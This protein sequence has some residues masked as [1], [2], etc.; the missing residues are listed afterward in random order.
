M[1]FAPATDQTVKATCRMVAR[2]R[3]FIL[4][5]AAYRYHL[6]HG[7]L[8]ASFAEID[9]SLV[10]GDM[11]WEDLIQDPFD[12]QSLRVRSDDTGLLIYSVFQNLVDD[13]GD[14]AINNLKPQTGDLGFQVTIP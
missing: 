9:R 7:R 14:V 10:P 2:Q 8:P 4:G 12:G 5:L 11:R 6:K 3:C 1:L 13:G